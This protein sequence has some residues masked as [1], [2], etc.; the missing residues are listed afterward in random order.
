MK[1]F[2]ILFMILSILVLS[3]C[4]VKNSA[5]NDLYD[6]K[7]FYNTNNIC[8]AQVENKF[9]PLDILKSF[10]G[11]ILGIAYIGNIILPFDISPLLDTAA[12]F[13]LKKDMDTDQ[14]KCEKVKPSYDKVKQYIIY[15]STNEEK[16]NSN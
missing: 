1:R 7:I 6:N 8:L 2:M 12:S 3:G 16:E 14:K 9:M 15:G 5:Q 13:T 4:G 10:A 11:S